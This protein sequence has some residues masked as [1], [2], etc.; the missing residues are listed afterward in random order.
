MYSRTSRFDDARFDLPRLSR[1]ALMMPTLLVVATLAT[2]CGGGQ[3]AAAPQAPPPTPVKVA[4][5]QS[6]SLADASEFVA[7]IKSLSSTSINPQVDGVITRILVKSGDRVKNGQPLLQIDPARQVAS[8]SS[9]DAARAAQEANVGFAQQQLNR[10][11]EL[12]TA[13]AISKQELEQA[14]TNFNTAKAQLDSLSAQVREQRVTL[15]YYQ[16][17][18]PT[19]G[20]VGDVPV[21]VGMRVN[22]DTVLTTIDQNQDLE[23]YVSVPL[24]RAG[25]LKVG[26]PI[27]LLDAAGK[28]LADTTVSFISPRADDQTQTVL[29]K[30]IIKSGATPT[31]RSLQFVR[32][33][34]IWKTQPGLTVPVVAVI[35]IN[36]AHFVY[37]AESQ[38]GKTVAKQRAVKLGQ[39]LKDDYTVIDGLKPN[40][41]VVVSGVQKLGD[42]APIAPQA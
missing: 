10:S 26:L 38:G 37:V 15:Q 23:T 32:A 27:E 34:V 3:Q 1:A 9:Q 36:G 39:I 7:T 22:P 12:L 14:E 18:A 11:K 13:G 31:L 2:A 4:T 8:V 5:I 41:Q 29:V 6:Q 42:G 40:E 16:V 17:L 33:R 20:I 25:E 19:S 24:E 30:G 28:K 21:R 35:R